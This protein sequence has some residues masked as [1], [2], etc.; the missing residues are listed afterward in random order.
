MKHKLVR[1]ALVV[2]EAFVALGAVAGGIALL[3]GTFAQGIPVAWLQGTPFSDYTIPGLVLAIVVGG[4]MGVAA[5]TVFIHREWAV[6]ISVVAGIF[7]VGFEVVEAASVDSKA[8]NGLPLMAGLQ[9][10]YFVLGLAIFGLATS[11]WMTEYRYHSLLT[12]HARHAS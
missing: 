11:L 10:F 8:G 1:I 4:G 6:L 12:R 9:V 5:V 2:L 3:T 7:M